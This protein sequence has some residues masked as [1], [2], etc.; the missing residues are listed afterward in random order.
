MLINGLS[1][2]FRGPG[3]HHNFDDS[4]SG[5]EQTDMDQSAKGIRDRIIVGES[6]EILTYSGDTEMFDR[7]EEDKDLESE[8]HKSEPAQDASEMK[9]SAPPISDAIPEKLL[10]PPRSEETLPATAASKESLAKAFEE[11]KSK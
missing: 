8:V 11:S 7:S 5:Y 9:G 2:E 1:A 3:M 6:G 4:D 10:N